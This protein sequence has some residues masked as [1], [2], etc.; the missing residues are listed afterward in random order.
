VLVD[1]QHDQNQLTKNTPANAR[2][3]GAKPPLYTLKNFIGR[4]HP[5]GRQNPLKAKLQY[6]AQPQAVHFTATAT[7]SAFAV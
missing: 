3:I 1:F 2:N 4:A 7:K 6:G 5:A